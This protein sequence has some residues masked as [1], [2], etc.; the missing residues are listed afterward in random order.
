MTGWRSNEWN[1][2][3]MGDNPF[4]VT[5]WHHWAAQGRKKDKVIVETHRQLLHEY[6]PSLL[7]SLTNT[8]RPIE[9]AGICCPL[10]TGMA[11]SDNIQWHMSDALNSGLTDQISGPYHPQFDT[12][13]GKRTGLL[14]L[15]RFIDRPHQEETGS[16]KQCLH[17]CQAA[18][19]TQTLAYITLCYWRSADTNT[20]KQKPKAYV[21]PSILTQAT[22]L[23]TTPTWEAPWKRKSAKP[24]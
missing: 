13:D 8:G 7:T 3:W 11:W 23:H 22:P 21:T 12:S 10:G 4:D 20:P 1:A 15:A 24:F 18:T 19:H 5:Q 14:S 17:S 9:E 16:P 6:I 2:D